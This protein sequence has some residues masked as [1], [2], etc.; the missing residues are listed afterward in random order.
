MVNASVIE[1]LL[2]MVGD[3]SDDGTLRPAG[4]FQSPK[5]RPKTASL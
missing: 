2:S 4:P 3:H 5:Q 1:E